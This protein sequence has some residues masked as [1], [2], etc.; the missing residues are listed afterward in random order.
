MVQMSAFSEKHLP[1]QNYNDGLDYL[2]RRELSDTIFQAMAKLKLMYRNIL[3]LRCFEQMSYAEIADLLGCKE[4]RARVLFFRAKYLLKKQLSQ[5]GF[6]RE[7]LL[8]SLGL[9]GLMTASTKAASAAGTVTATSLDVGFTA[10]LIGAAGTKLGIA[11]MT[12]MTALILTLSVEKFIFLI[13]LLC[14]VSI[15]FVVVIYTQR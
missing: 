6:G 13:V 12:A 1:E 5:R 14:Y 10:T 15:C 3:I 4:L 2:M 8:T 11:I 9:F 7:L